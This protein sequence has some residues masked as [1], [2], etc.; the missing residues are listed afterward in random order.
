MQSVVPDWID[1]L[2]EQLLPALQAAGLD[3]DL[4]S[5]LNIEA[6]IDAAHDRQLLSDDPRCAQGALRAIVS[7]S[8][9]DQQL[10]DQIFDAWRQRWDHGAELLGSTNAAEPSPS[11]PPPDQPRAASPARWSLRF[12]L[13]LFVA[14]AVSG[15]AVRYAYMRW[16]ETLTQRQVVQQEKPSP[17]PEATIDVPTFTNIKSVAG[18][19]EVRAS[20]W[21]FGTH[22]AIYAAL[23][24]ALA[25]AGLFVRR[26]RKA[27]IARITTGENLREQQVF[28][29]QLL[30]VS[31]ERRAALRV[32]ARRLRK[33]R[34][35]ERRYL[36]VN[37]STRATASR[38]GVFTPVHRQATAMPEYL[39][40]VDRAGRND[41]QAHWA[42]EMARDLAAE[43][44]TLAL[45]E[46]DRDPRWVAPLHTHRSM[47]LGAT[48]TFLP[49]SCLGARH[50]GQGLIV[51]GDGHSFIEPASGELH[52]WLPGALAPWPRR[53]LMTPR[54]PASWGLAEDIIAG[55]GQPAHVDSFLVLP[56]Q[57]EMLSAAAR[58]FDEREVPEVDLL[59]GAPALL[60][61]MLEDDI[62]RWVGREA[63]VATELVALVEQLRSF[64]GPT[65]YTWLAASAAYP[66]LSADLTAYLAHQLSEAPPSAARSGAA[67]SDAR[68][69]EARLVGIAQLPWCRLGMMPDWVRRAL[70][71]SLA[72]ATRERVRAVLA[73]LFRAAGQD[74]IALGVSLGTVASGGAAPTRRQPHSLLRSFARRI[75]LAGVVANEPPDSPL[76]DVIY[77]GVLRGDFD[78]EL[79]LD[80]GEDFA[81][82]VRSETGPR[83]TR[84]PLRWLAVLVVA[85]FYP[86]IW[87]KWWASGALPGEVAG[88]GRGFVQAWRTAYADVER[89]YAV[90]GKWFVRVGPHLFGA[91][92]VAPPA[93][94]DGAPQTEKRGELPSE[95]SGALVFLSYRR[96]EAAF[97]ARALRE[98]LVARLGLASVWD[99]LE[100]RAGAAWQD[101]IQRAL[102]RCTIL[103]V[104]IG[105]NPFAD[106]SPWQVEEI[107]HAL[108]A[109]KPIIPV[110]LDGAAMPGSAA[111]PP[112]IRQLNHY[113]AF[114]L[115]ADRPDADLDRLTDAIVRSVGER[116]NA[117]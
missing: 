27:Q 70:F 19:T 111:L 53:V 99:D 61:A 49:L 117:K 1:S 94:Q 106:D 17:A 68:L 12:W 89:F 57:I 79:T 66:Y 34:P 56:A 40:L 78:T 18:Q 2:R 81:R 86:V 91:E 29:R 58:W 96:S 47:G 112:S 104:F 11:R 74:D 84:N 85:E 83:L 109:G 93:E 30:P 59:P 108:A 69:L 72:P 67:S 45:Y 90:I 105:R 73:R 76:R 41:Q 98:R 101:E 114:P 32:A 113:H 24:L 25:S 51:L 103:V 15:L 110:L 14:L 22:P 33:P 20:P 80:A 13:A 55:E 4:R 36:D 77:L 71:L 44:V 100:L 10:F 97:A 35:S 107:A 31:G 64:L 46:F 3:L 60:P 5:R 8:A 116:T 50:A 115:H 62:G 95:A 9:R 88:L 102:D 39:L 87:L 16:Q 28:A 75:G 52:D 43:G 65:A 54:P 7:K 92:P 48:Q 21:L 6:W 37:A 42:A 38:G 63:P 82:A 23:I 26:T